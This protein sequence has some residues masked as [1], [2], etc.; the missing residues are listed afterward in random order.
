[1]TGLAPNDENR[2][3][4]VT[5]WKIRLR[6]RAVARSAADA[7]SRRGIPN[8]GLF[9]AADGVCG[10]EVRRASGACARWPVAVRARQSA[11]FAAVARGTGVA[12]PWTTTKVTKRPPFCGVP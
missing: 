2:A 11:R 6:C 4:T 5:R 3:T 8:R 1:M 9:Q 12:S 7:T 10:G